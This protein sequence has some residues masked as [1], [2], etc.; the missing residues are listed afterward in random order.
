LEGRGRDL[1]PGARLHRPGGQVRAAS[2]GDMLDA[3][4]DFCRVDLGLAEATAKEYGRKMRWFFRA[5]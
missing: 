3:F 4:C 2:V 5:S 1:N